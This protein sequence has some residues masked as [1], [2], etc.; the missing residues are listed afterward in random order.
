[1]ITSF[2]FGRRFGM[3][4]L[5]AVAVLAVP[6]SVHE[7]KCPKC[8]MD[9][10]QD[11]PTQDNEVALRY[12]H[13][14]I[15]CRSIA[16][17]LA[18]AKS[19]YKNDLTILAPS[20]TKNKPVVLSRTKSKWS[21]APETAVFVG[22]KTT[23]P[24]SCYLAQRAFTSRAAFDVHVKANAKLLAGAKPLSLGQMVEASK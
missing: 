18:E 5:A 24:P 15:E 10:V 21:V 23:G 17:A 2:V 22:E 1:M 16:C 14:R 8:K 6:A 11:T 7:T 13:K 4:L 12:G 19:E 3:A 9:V 20:E